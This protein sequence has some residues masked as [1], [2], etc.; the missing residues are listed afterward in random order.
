MSLRLVSVVLL[1]GCDGFGTVQRLHAPAVIDFVRGSAWP[2]LQ[3]EWKR[4]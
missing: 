1:I 2:G 3:L 4:S